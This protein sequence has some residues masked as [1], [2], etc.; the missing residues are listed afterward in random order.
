MAWNPSPKVADCRD[1]ARKWHDKDMVIIIAV[2]HEGRFEMATYGKD[3][4]LCRVAKELGDK[5]FDHLEAFV[6]GIDNIP[7]G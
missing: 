7:K 5:A 6:N 4:E 3:S 2:D 1:I